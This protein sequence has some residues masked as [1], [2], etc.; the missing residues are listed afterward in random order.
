MSD[1]ESPWLIDLLGKSLFLNGTEVQPQRKALDLIAGSGVELTA[2]DAEGRTKI[3]ISGDE[4][5]KDVIVDGA[6]APKRKTI[7][8]VAGTGIA[9]SFVDVA[10]KTV[11]TISVS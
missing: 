2:S 9:L 3:T 11:V 5:G 6:V 10:G 4:T 8:F 7:E 1:T